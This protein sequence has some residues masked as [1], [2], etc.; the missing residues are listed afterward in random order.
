MC[1]ARAAAPS[2][3][4]EARCAA[5]NSR[6][7][8]LVV[9]WSKVTKIQSSGARRTKSSSSARVRWKVWR[10]TG[11]AKRTDEV[12]CSNCSGPGNRFAYS[13]KR[14]GRGNAKPTPST[15]S[16]RPMSHEAT[17]WISLTISAWPKGVVGRAAASGCGAMAIVAT[18]W[19]RVMRRRWS[20]S[21]RFQKRVKRYMATMSEGA[22]SRLSPRYLSAPARI[23]RDHRPSISSPMKSDTHSYMRTNCSRVTRAPSW[24]SSCGER[25][26]CAAS[27]SMSRGLS[28]RRAPLSRCCRKLTA[29]VARSGGMAW[30][31][32]KTVGGICK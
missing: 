5:T 9:S 26:A 8:A 31:R 21:S 30:V 25:P 17:P 20:S 2:V 23:G 1:T 16:C 27:R 32:E 3:A 12:S 14:A 22:S 18:P 28:W 10:S 11:S 4:S 13:S 24:R 6:T 29:T 7:V 19:A 15:G